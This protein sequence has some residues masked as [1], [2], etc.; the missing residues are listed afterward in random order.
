MFINSTIGASVIAH[1]P[2]PIESSDQLLQILS[3]TVSA[4]FASPAADFYEAPISLDELLNIRAP[5][6]WIVQV[7][8]DSMNGAG[9]FNGTRLIVDRA[10]KPRAGR[11]VLAYVDGQPVVKRL[12]KASGGWSLM[13]ANAAYKTIHPD[14]YSSIEVFGVV[15]WFL[16]KDD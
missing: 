4:G 3:G 15:T 12:A 9:I 6:V 8:G 7:A 14:Q 13:S 1:P 11:I 2:Q 10:E 16:T 5:H